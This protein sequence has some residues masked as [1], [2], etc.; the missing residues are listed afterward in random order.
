MERACS[1][2]MMAGQERYSC[3]GL[4]SPSMVA[5]V[6]ATHAVPYALV[7]GGRLA[8]QACGDPPNPWCTFAIALHWRQ[9]VPLV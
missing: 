3:T 1:L 4:A 6:V 8:Y 5:T 7:M 9:P 2:P